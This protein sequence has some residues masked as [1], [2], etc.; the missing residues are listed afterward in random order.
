[1]VQTPNASSKR[2]WLAFEIVDSFEEQMPAPDDQYVEEMPLQVMSDE[3]ET[4]IEDG[5]AESVAKDIV[6]LWDD[7]R[8]GK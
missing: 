3:F 8:I 1:M 4:V 5:S 7:T 6:K 2:T